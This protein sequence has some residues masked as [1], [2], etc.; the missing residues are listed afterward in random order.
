MDLVSL[1][2][3]YIYHPLCAFFKSTDEGPPV[4]ICCYVKLNKKFKTNLYNYYAFSLLS[5]PC[6]IPQTHHK[7]SVVEG[8]PSLNLVL[9][10]GIG[11]RHAG[12]GLFVMDN[13]SVNHMCINALNCP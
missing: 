8:T 11:E 1:H 9:F 6:L 7:A 4:S 13:I 5:S 2:F 3:Q 12:M 10:R